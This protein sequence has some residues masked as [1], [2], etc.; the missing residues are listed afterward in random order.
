MSRRWWEL[1]FALGA[2]A[3][4]GITVITVPLD[5]LGAWAAGTLG[6]LLVVGA[7]ICVLSWPPGAAAAEP[8]T[9]WR[10][11]YLVPLLV[12]AVV[13][14]TLVDHRPGGLSPAAS[15]VLFGFTAYVA[16][17]GGVAVFLVLL[18]PVAALLRSMSRR[19]RGETDS[20]TSI[21]GPA[22]AAL[23]LSVTVFSFGG[24]FAL[25]G[26][27][28]TET[29]LFWVMGRVAGVP[30]PGVTVASPGWLLVARLGGAGML[31]SGVAIALAAKRVR[32]RTPAA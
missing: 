1:A 24:A 32:R 22:T 28:N 23:I 21:Y 9:P 14:R 26:V 4:A 12:T 31:A 27:P 18:L 2:A 16:L 5:R 8:R 17:L 10:A 25:D 7:L 11:V 20:S 15:V 6:P 29:G 13:A 3:V 30:L 19:V